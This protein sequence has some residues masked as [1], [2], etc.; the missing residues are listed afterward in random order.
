MLLAQAETVG[1]VVD[2]ATKS[3]TDTGLIGVLLV[4]VLVSIGAF[5]VVLFRFCAP[6]LRDIATSTVELHTSLKETNL[7]L[8]VTLD[9]VTNDHGSK[10]SDIK[11][12]VNANRC[13]ALNQTS[14]PR[15]PPP[16]QFQ[17]TGGA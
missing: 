17:P 6:L 7:K 12:A 15:V 3:A 4:L 10:L 14:G 11:E 9:Q 13:P 8:A 2:A 16:I 1:R 5:V